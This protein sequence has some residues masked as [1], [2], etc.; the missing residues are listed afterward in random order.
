PAPAGSIKVAKASGPHAYSIAELYAQKDKL[1][2]QKVVVR[3]QVVKAT[4]NIMKRN[5]IH[6][7]DGT[8]DPA[9]GTFDLTVTSQE[10]PKVGEVVVI[11]GEL[12]VDRDFGAGYRY[13]LI[14]ENA[15][16]KPGDASS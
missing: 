6:L 2:N 11:E 15:T 3:A 1:A 9:K 8:G 10:L 4:P 12:H 16:V 13:G 14:I 7:Q 5:W